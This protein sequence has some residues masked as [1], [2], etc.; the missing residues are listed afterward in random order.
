MCGWW[1]WL[2][3]GYLDKWV[4]R[5]SK[6]LAIHLYQQMSGRENLQNMRNDKDG[7]Y[8]EIHPLGQC[9][10]EVRAVAGQTPVLPNHCNTLDCC[11]AAWSPGAAGSR[12][13]G[14]PC[15]PG[16]G[17]AGELPCGRGRGCSPPP[18]PSSPAPPRLASP[19]PVGGWRAGLGRGIPS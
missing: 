7:T 17:A 5:S 12:G 10:G 18:P 6:F 14:P 15:P 4:F 3:G 19:Q 9:G 13:C 1:R 8:L 2:V 11:A 16:G